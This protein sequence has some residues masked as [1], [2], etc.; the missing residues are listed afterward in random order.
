MKSNES[1]LAVEDGVQAVGRGEAVPAQ[2]DA[3][4]GVHRGV[5]ATPRHRVEQDHAGK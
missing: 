4:G 5:P 3:H 2:R 1:N